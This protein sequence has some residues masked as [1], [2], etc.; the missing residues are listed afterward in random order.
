[1]NSAIASILAAAALL[2]LLVGCLLISN[3]YTTAD[4]DV[5]SQALGPGILRAIGAA[6][7]DPVHTWDH[8]EE[9]CFWL[10]DGTALLGNSVFHFGNDNST[11]SGYG[12]IYTPGTRIVAPPLVV[13]VLGKSLACR[14]NSTLRRVLQLLLLT[15]ADI[16][17]AYC[18]YMLA[19][20]I[21]HIERNSNEAEMERHTILSER[22]EERNEAFNEDLVIPVI[23]RPEMG[24]TIG[25][26]SKRS[27]IIDTCSKDC[28][29]VAGDDVTNH[30]KHLSEEDHADNGRST[31]AHTKPSTPPLD[32]EPLLVL[33]QLPIVASLFYIG[34]PISMLANATGSLRSLWDS[35]LLL[36]FYY[37]TMP[38]TV[39]SKNGIPNNNPTATMLAMLLALA[40]YVDPG[41]A[42]F[43]FPILLWRGL[44]Q[45]STSSKTQH[46][47]W[48]LVLLL[49]TLH[50]GGLH[51]FASLLVGGGPK[52][53][54][55]V[56]IQTILPNVA[57]VQQD[58]SGSV[59]GPSMGLHW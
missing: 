49:Y 12:A 44:S 14:P 46:Y 47:D 50:L 18:M 58:S 27:P 8:L 30:D 4:G 57:F 32:K 6:I 28:K 43:M 24:W 31:I 40:T 42:M 15:I 56:M 21:I 1:M 48:K 51:Y 41:Y 7:L 59:P 16:V 11:N 36:S 17:G 13:A 10:E 23:L 52:A 25:L 38:V 2:R 5:F 54:S 19:Y 9:A 20:Q 22:F 45:S 34:N 35:L 29:S 33:E 55:N 37:A 26:P 39:I 53:Y 3:N